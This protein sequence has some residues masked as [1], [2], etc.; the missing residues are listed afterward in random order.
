MQVRQVRIDIRI[1]RRPWWQT[2]EEIRARQGALRAAEDPL[3]AKADLVEIQLMK[4]TDDGASHQVVE[5]F[6]VV[7]VDDAS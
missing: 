7:H 3:R 5:A 2:R 4:D 6:R 1:S